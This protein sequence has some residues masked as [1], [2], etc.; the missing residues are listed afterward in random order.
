M[1]PALASLW[2]QNYNYG[3]KK[4]VGTKNSKYWCHQNY[5]K[6]NCDKLFNFLGSKLNT[7]FH[8]FL[9]WTS[10]YKI[11]IHIYISTYVQYNV[12]VKNMY[13]SVFIILEMLR[14]SLF[15]MTREKYSYKKGRKME[16]QPNRWTMNKNCIEM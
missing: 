1:C 14:I 15:L 3:K 13:L 11:Y 16:R 10:R 2:G 4:E 8:S 7:S 6:T 12:I 9:F 5:I